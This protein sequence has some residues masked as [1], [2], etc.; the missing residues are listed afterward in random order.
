MNIGD[1]L[2]MRPSIF[3]KDDGT[4]GKTL[5]CRVVYIHPQRR[6]FTVEFRSEITGLTFRESFPCS[7]RAEIIRE[8]P[9]AEIV[10]H[11]HLS[12]GRLKPG[13]I[14]DTKG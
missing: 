3:T 8:K 10:P 2:I 11:R 4:R 14:Y 6:F 12:P 7:D 9:K 13:G 5:P 1:E